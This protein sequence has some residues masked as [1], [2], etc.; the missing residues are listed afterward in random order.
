M[1]GAGTPTVIAAHALPRAS[2]AE[3]LGIGLGRRERPRR[4]GS[5]SVDP[6]VVHEGQ[7][8]LDLP[9]QPEGAA[10]MDVP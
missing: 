5:S 9:G 2:L 3:A 4:R 10:S 7:A 8:Q 6:D 1:E